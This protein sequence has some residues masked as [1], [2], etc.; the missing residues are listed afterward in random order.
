MS[1]FVGILNLDGAPVERSLLEGMT[2]S[3]AFRGPD[4]EGRWCSGAVGL[5]H[6]LLR[7]SPLTAS[8]ADADG[9]SD[10]QPANCGGR[11]WIVA[12]ARIDA[13]AELIGKLKAKSGAASCVSLSTPDSLLILHAYDVWGDGCVEHLIGDFSF[14][15]WD[16]AK[17]KLFCVRDQIGI[18]PFYYAR[19]GN[20]LIFSNTLQV[21]RPYPGVS[22]NLSDLAIGD[23]LLFGVNY[24]TDVSVFEDIKKLPGAH[25]LTAYGEQICVKRYWSFP[26]EEPIF[27][28][29][30][31]DCIQEFRTLLNAAVKDR[32]RTDRA[33]IS[34]SGGLDSTTVAAAAA[35]QLT[36]KA[37]L[38]GI[39]IASD[40]T[41]PDEERKYAGIVANHLQIP[42]RFYAPGDY[43]LFERCESSGFHFPEPNGFE[44]AAMHEDIYQFAAAH[45]SV[46][47]TGEGGDPGLIPSLSF[48]RGR[49]LPSFLWNAAKYILSHGRHPRLGF[50]LAWLRWRGLPTA[51]TGSY[52]NWL[53]PQF[54][55]RARLRERWQE[56]MSEKPSSHPDRPAAYEGV[57]QPEWAGFFELYDMGHTRIFLE[58]R[59]PLMDLRVL[60]F[61]VRLPTLPWCADKELLRLAM[62]P[63]LP[64]TILRRPKSPLAGDPLAELVRNETPE[65]LKNF[66]PSAQLGN[67]VVR[68]QVPPHDGVGF[69][70]EP[71]LHLRP[72]SLNFW[73]R[74]L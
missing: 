69:Q 46:M 67:Y 38:M 25:L 17:R 27:H 36:G 10:K 74:S 50:H 42:L 47:L 51:D 6:T 30:P 33:S 59:H 11:L 26:I 55:F 54:E 8:M 57:S 14:A 19:I 35:S 58:I 62:R 52:P 12:D 28:P 44:L 23:Y 70:S 24:R 22:Q 56:I 53:E 1:G 29:R 43:E 72:I 49:R 37:A 64:E 16:A 7:M 21:L 15:I 71:T 18:K 31:G 3:L 13:R 73:L 48:Y 2:R 39:T 61:M 63:D 45:S 41:I 4:E 32:L 66:A 9:D 68:T 5:G 20:T 40:Q 34:L 60:R 65:W